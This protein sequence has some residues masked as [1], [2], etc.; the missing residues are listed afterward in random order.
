MPRPLSPW[1]QIDGSLVGAGAG[2]GFLWALISIPVGSPW[3]DA[4]WSPLWEQAL[5]ILLC[6][7][8]FVG[9]YGN[10]LLGK[11]GVSWAMFP[12]ILLAGG[13]VGALVGLIL[14]YRL[15]R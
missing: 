8:L 15:V 4:P 12:L 9:V 7:P 13:T 1:S 5:V 3:F 2:L 6:F 14:A 11:V 10:V